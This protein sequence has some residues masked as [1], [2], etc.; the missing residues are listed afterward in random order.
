MA[1]MPIMSTCKLL[2]TPVCSLADTLWHIAL[3]RGSGTKITSACFPKTVIYSFFLM[4][5]SSLP[6]LLQQP[7]SS[8]WRC[9]GLLS[10]LSGCYI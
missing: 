8:P 6:C 10:L 9:C 2:T 5:S 7:Y 3:K 4:L 1:F